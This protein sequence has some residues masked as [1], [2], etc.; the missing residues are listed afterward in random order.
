M[1]EMLIKAD[2]QLRQV[3]HPLTEVTV[4]THCSFKADVQQA[5]QAVA[6]SGNPDPI[7]LL[8]SHGASPDP[9]LLLLT[10]L[11]FEESEHERAPR[12]R[13]CIDEVLYA[14]PGS[15]L[16]AQ[17][18]RQGANP[19]ATMKVGENAKESISAG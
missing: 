1:I 12:L 7:A 10:V 18:L 15:A 3:R 11:Y 16:R 9:A 13:K 6:V 4:L 5:L 19:S 8:V 17:L 14:C 2:K